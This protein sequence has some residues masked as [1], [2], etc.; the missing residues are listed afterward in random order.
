MHMN[1]YIAGA[2]YTF[3]FLYITK[4]FLNDSV[5]TPHQTHIAASKNFLC[6]KSI[7]CTYV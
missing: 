6:I 3:I 4:Q 2:Y 1:E 5:K 7:M